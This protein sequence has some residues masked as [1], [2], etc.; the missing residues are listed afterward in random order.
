MGARPGRQRPCP[1]GGHRLP[2]AG[3]REPSP[4]PRKVGG[5]S[6]ETP[7]RQDAE[8]GI[9]GR[10]SS[11]ATSEGCAAP[12]CG[13]RAGPGAEAAHPQVTREVAAVPAGRDQGKGGTSGKVSAGRRSSGR[14][15][16]LDPTPGVA[17]RCHHPLC[18]AEARGS[19]RPQ[20]WDPACLACGRPAQPVPC[21]TGVPFRSRQ[22]QKPRTRAV[23]D[24]IA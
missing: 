3:R 20:R 2:G 12:R 7:Q 16:A 8:C 1:V 4:E 15:S 11:R 9:H 18:T 17:Q 13:A 19:P 23:M 24:P 6:Q 21:L 5:P 10:L 22:R 14:Q